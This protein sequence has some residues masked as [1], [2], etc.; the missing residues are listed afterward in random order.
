M[1][2][3]DVLKAIKEIRGKSKK[4]GFKQAFD[5][6]L[7]LKGIDIKKPENQ[8]ELFI[9]LPHTPKKKKVCA[10][11]GGELKEEAAKVCDKVIVSDEFAIY[12][13]DKK[14]VKK[15]SDEYDYFVA[16]ANVMPAAATSFGRVFGPRGKMPNPKA[17]C[18]VPPKFLMKPLYERLQKTA[19][20]AWK[21]SL[22]LQ[23]LIGTEEMTDEQIADNAMAY[24]N[25]VLHNLPND[26]N[27]VRAVYLKL[28][29]G[30]PVRI[31]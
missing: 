30:T 18:V 27:N 17:G 11:V 13:K 6:I 15:L 21:K 1:E 8:K 24:Y 31:A 5:L 29:M 4:R 12:G 7:N 10:L 14:A 20:A 19:K 16:Q 26:T 28:T 22:V 9:A 25:T 23:A 3:N 2:K